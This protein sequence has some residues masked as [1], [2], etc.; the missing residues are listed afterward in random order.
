[1]GIFLTFASLLAS[2]FLSVITFL[3]PAFQRLSCTAVE[4]ER[5]TYG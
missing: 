3:L 2:S 1:M 5:K 4:L